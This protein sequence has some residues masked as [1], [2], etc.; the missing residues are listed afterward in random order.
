M[1]KYTV[2]LLCIALYLSGTLT[3]FAQT[4][5]KPPEAEI[6]NG[7]I[8]ARIYLPDSTTGYNR[9]PR[10]DWAGIISN[11]TYHGH[12]YFGKWQEAYSPAAHDAAMGPAEVFDPMGFDA[13]KPGE[14]FIKIGVGALVKPDTAPYN[15]MKPYTIA[16]YGKWTVKAKANRIEFL[17]VLQEGEYAYEYHKRVQLKTGAPVMLI[18]HTLRN[19]GRHDIETSVYDHNFFVIDTTTT[20]PGLVVVFPV[21]LKENINR[22][23][24]YIK[25]DS[26][27]L[28]FIKEL[29][30]KYISFPDVTR[31]NG[32]PY[33]IQ[34][35]NQK[36][37]AGVKIT[38]DHPMVKLAFW[39]SP[40]TVC[41]EP[42]IN[43]R[44]KPGQEF[45]WTLTYTYYTIHP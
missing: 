36:T 29:K 37:G 35:E 19:T 30:N 1:K 41:P 27:R 34:V 16:N 15:F 2:H 26:N 23:T 31:G 43:I 45:S 20:G 13:A 21:N 25:I 24:D 14:K 40:K 32:A 11:V 44:I 42:Y 39:S 17:Q 8:H 18:T 5:V 3:L 33:A 4:G 7:L 6:T 12:S 10:F 38:G 28:Q 9:G 22:L